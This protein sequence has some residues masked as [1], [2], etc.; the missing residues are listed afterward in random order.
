MKYE[1][2]SRAKRGRGSENLPTSSFWYHPLCAFSNPNIWFSDITRLRGIQFRG[3]GGSGGEE[4]QILCSS[5][6]EPSPVTFLQIL[7]N[8]HQALDT[9]K[10]PTTY[11][12]PICAFLDGHSFY[13]IRNKCL[14][15]DDQGLGAFAGATRQANPLS[16]SFKASGSSDGLAALRQSRED[17]FAL[18][19]HNFTDMIEKKKQKIKEMEEKKAK[20]RL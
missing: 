15:T 6:N 9:K 17:R 4:K 10:P 19:R 11:I 5:C 20:E 14:F 18:F 3:R 7:N 13:L 8:N 16:I 12:H 1:E 2:G